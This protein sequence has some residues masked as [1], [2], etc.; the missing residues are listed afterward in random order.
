MRVIFLKRR[1]VIIITLILL[2]CFLAG[3]TFFSFGEEKGVELPILMYHSIL[4]DYCRTCKYVI[5]PKQFEQDLIYI[6]NS[7]Y[8]TVNV[9]DL[10]D[11]V[12]N[13]KKLPENPIMI[14]FDDGHYD[15]MVYALPLLI[16]YDMKAV[17][18]VIGEYS[19]NHVD[20]TIYSYLSWEK[21]KELCDTN[22][23]EIQNHTYNLHGTGKRIGI[24]PLKYEENY[25]E[26]LREDLLKNQEKIKNAIGTEPAAFAYPFGNAP[27]EAREIIKEL[28]KSSFSCTE[29]INYITKDPNSLYMLKRYN[30]PS[31][32]SAKEILK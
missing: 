23:F 12:Y 3:G 9:K 8:E 7:G 24:K 4:N 32:K 30:R 14:T 13:N 1:N 16:E 17:I 29:G 20:N 25:E 22:R 5:T 21:M 28:F 19:D 18:S 6:K 2:L 15:N 26:M 31:S 11:Y 10:I 27:K